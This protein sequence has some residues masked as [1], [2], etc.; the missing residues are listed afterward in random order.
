MADSMSRFSGMELL[1]ARDLA[2]PARAELLHPP[3]GPEAQQLAIYVAWL[4]NGTV[5]Y[6]WREFYDFEP[7]LSKGTQSD[8]IVTARLGVLVALQTVASTSFPQIE[9]DIFNI[10]AWRIDS[11]FVNKSVVELVK[12]Y[13]DPFLAYLAHPTLVSIARDEPIGATFEVYSGAKVSSTDAPA[14]PV[15]DHSVFKMT[16]WRGLRDLSKYWKTPKPALKSLT[17][18]CVG[19]GR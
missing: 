10:N 9:K 2:F 19:P 6:Q 17:R 12:G 4:P 16:M 7:T 15:T 11:V 1:L 14:D 3:A 18:N 8:R 5:Q 13:D